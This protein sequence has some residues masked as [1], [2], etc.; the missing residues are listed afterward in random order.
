MHELLA[1]R[2]SRFLAWRDSCCVA[3]TVLE[4]LTSCIKR[5]IRNE[6]GAVTE[7]PVGDADVSKTFQNNVRRLETPANFNKG[8]TLVYYYRKTNECRF[9]E[10][11]NLN[12]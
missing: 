3:K 8:V 5:K 11:A 1:I 12:I 6:H 2:H 7:S 10:S 9:T 4:L